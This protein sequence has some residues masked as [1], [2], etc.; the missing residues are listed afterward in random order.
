MSLQKKS[1]QNISD[2]T[3]QTSKNAVK[4]AALKQPA[5]RFLLMRFLW[6][7]VSM[8]YDFWLLHNFWPEVAN[9]DLQSKKKKIL[10]QFGSW[11]E[12]LVAKAKL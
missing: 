9:P 8:Y 12:A 5:Q 3:K 10:S 11:V 2:F 4:P 6:K 1:E 7:S